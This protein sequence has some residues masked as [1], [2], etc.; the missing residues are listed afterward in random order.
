M[1]LGRAIKT[2]VEALM[3]T[4]VTAVAETTAKIV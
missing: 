2:T 4:L 3:G 1:T